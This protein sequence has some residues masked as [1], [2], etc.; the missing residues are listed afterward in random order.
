V[1]VPSGTGPA[2]VAAAASGLARPDERVEGRAVG[3]AEGSGV[4]LGDGARIRFDDVDLW[5]QGDGGGREDLLSDLSLVIEAM[6][7]GGVRTRGEGRASTGG[8]VRWDLEVDPDALR[9]SGSVGFHDLPLA[10]VTPLLPEVPWYQAERGRLDADLRIVGEGLER[11]ALEG[12]LAFRDAAFSSARVAPGPV[13]G[14]SF[15]VQGRGVFVPARRR[16]EID[17]GRLEVGRAFATVQGALEWAPEH[18]LF[19]VTAVLPPTACGVA[20][21]AIPQDLLAELRGFSVTGQMSARARVLVDSRQLDASRVEVRVQDACEFVTVPAAADL[22]RFDGPFVHRVLEPDGSTF[23]MQTGPGTAAW[24]PIERVSPFLIHAVLA[25]EDGGFFRHHGFAPSEIQTALVR[26]LMAGRYVQGAS[27]ITMQLVKNVFLHREKT[28]ARKV[29]EA[30][31]TWW[32]E[33][34]FDKRRILELYLNVIEY[35]PGVYGIRQ[36]SQHYFGREPAELTVAQAGFLAM[37]LPSPKSFQEMYE[38]GT[39]SARFADRV[40]AFV[41]R[42]EAKG[43]IDRAAL[44]DGLAEL[45][46]F[47]FHRPGAELPPPRRPVGT[48][49][50]LPFETY[51]GDDD[52]WAGVDEETAREAQRWLEYEDAR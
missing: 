6:S 26:N 35:G 51:V 19:D 13:R 41:R 2:G 27:T 33:R 14:I 28:L 17:E 38:S 1:P 23:E 8:A 5:T 31:L 20:V 46:R 7:G 36:A 44:E 34:V 32:I 21:D 22:R 52:G 15:V 11:V 4:R 42:M 45:D 49:Q 3:H 37:I 12:R 47:A 9:A 25:H 16:L 29:Q 43:R 48:A 18:Y 30:L 50:P 24:V 39:L 40:R 10:L